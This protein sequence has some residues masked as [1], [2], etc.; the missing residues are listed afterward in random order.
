MLCVD[1]ATDAAVPVYDVVGFLRAD[2]AE[3]VDGSVR[4]CEVGVLTRTA[5]EAS[6]R[7]LA[8]CQELTHTVG[9]SYRNE[10]TPPL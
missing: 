1:M 3:R 5:G 8:A 7:A 6:G 4:G 9:Q 2:D 10:L